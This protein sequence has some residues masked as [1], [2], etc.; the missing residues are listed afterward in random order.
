MFLTL[1]IVCASQ[2]ERLSNS[3]YIDCGTHSVS[4]S[5]FGEFSQV[6]ETYIHLRNKGS[7]NIKL[8]KY[9]GSR[10]N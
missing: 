9:L 10:E 1:Y 3:F 7:L 8:L 4:V 6:S 5:S 2:L